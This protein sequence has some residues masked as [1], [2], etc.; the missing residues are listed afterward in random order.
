M[1]KVSLRF[2]DDKDVMLC[3]LILNSLDLLLPVI[4]D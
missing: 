1:P 2:D 4:I 3:C